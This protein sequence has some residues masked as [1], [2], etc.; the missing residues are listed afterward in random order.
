MNYFLLAETDF[1]RLINEAGDCNMET[2]YTAFA[3]Q[4]IEL[5]NGGMDMNLTVIALAYIEI[6]LQHH[7]VRNLSE[8]KREI[9]AYVSKALSFVR[10]MQKFLATP[11]VPPLISANNATETTASLLQWTGNA[12]DL[13]ELIY[14]IDV[15]GC[16]NNGNMPLKQL[17][18]LLYKIFGVDSIL[19]G[20]LAYNVGPAKLL[21][22]KTIPKSTLIKKLEAGDRNIYR[23]YIAFCNYKGKRHAMLL[24]RRKAEFALLYIP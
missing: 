22:S 9:A 18:P 20:T 17:A 12:I 4:V 19:L 6:E 10:K 15:M 16:I 14:G 21:G 2:A 8:E 11:Q 5:C 3:T 24:K 13:V 23:E 7:P 1:F